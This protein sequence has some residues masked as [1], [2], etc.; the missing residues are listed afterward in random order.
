MYRD[1]VVRWMNINGALRGIMY[2]GEK[3]FGSCSGVQCLYTQVLL[4]VKLCK[5][6]LLYNR[7]EMLGQVVCVTRESGECSAGDIGMMRN[8]VEKS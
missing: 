4:R 1:V 8:V 2:Y 6:M 3:M 7:I 5:G